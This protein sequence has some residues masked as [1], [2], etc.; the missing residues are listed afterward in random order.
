MSDGLRFAFLTSKKNSKSADYVRRKILFVDQYLFRIPSI[1]KQRSEHFCYQKLEKIKE[2]LKQLLSWFRRIFQWQQ[3]FTFTIGKTMLLN[4]AISHAQDLFKDMSWSLKKLCKG[5]LWNK[6]SLVI[7]NNTNGSKNKTKAYRWET[8][9]F[10]TIKANKLAY[11]AALSTW[12][13][14]VTQAGML[15]RNIYNSSILKWNSSNV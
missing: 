12:N 4:S 13:M 9:R 8:E 7:E 14:Q 5:L 1:I 3:I 11:R 10:K 15:L 2:I 6:S